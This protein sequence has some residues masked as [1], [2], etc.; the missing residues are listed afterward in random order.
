MNG[1]NE[2][3]IGDSREMLATVNDE[4]VDLVYIDPPYATGRNFGDFCDKFDS[5]KEYINQ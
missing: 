1:I 2:Y 3:H 4:C 5:K